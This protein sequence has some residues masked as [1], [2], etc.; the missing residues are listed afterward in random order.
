MPA[1]L[2]VVV[3]VQECRFYV[4][5]VILFLAL[6]LGCSTLAQSLYVLQRFRL[7]LKETEIQTPLSRRYLEAGPGLFSS[8]STVTVPPTSNLPRFPSQKVKRT[9]QAMMA[10]ESESTQGIIPSEPK[11]KARLELLKR[12][13]DL[14]APD[15]STLGNL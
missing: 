13:N 14:E 11:S 5:K 9:S 3:A 8:R 10:S 2:I 4:L 1:P 12:F 15:R 7:W 6:K